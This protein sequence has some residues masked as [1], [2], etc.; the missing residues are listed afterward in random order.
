MCLDLIT[1]R[2]FRS[3]RD[4]RYKIFR[5]NLALEADEAISG[6]Y[7]DWAVYRVGVEYEARKTLA[8]TLTP[9]DKYGSL[10]TSGFH[11]LVKQR[12]AAF[13]RDF[14]NRHFGPEPIGPGEKYGELD[15]HKSYYFDAAL[16]EV[17]DPIAAGMFLGMQADVWGK[18]KIIRFLEIDEGQPWVATTLAIPTS[19]SS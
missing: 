5:R 6:F 2:K 12:D 18:M 11:C 19:Q 4:R 9:P 15:M 14:L 7:A 16:V 13:L 17:S 10:Y 1:S 3:E 8:V